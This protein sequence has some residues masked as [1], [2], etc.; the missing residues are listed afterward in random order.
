MHM[1]QNPIDH[2]TACDDMGV[3]QIKMEADGEK[4]SSV[5]CL[6]FSFR[7]VALSLWSK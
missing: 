1:T 3:Q 7:G 4:A 6:L 5:F 2:P